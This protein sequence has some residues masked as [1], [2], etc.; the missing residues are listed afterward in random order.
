MGN[1]PY[2]RGNKINIKDA[3][4]F[5]C[6]M[7]TKLDCIIRTTK[8]IFCTFCGFGEQVLW[9]VFYTGDDMI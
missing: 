4:I 2:I 7:K 6:V 3:Y 9:K 5:H 8:G 1:I